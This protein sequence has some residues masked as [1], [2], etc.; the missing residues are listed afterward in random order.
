MSPTFAMHNA[1]DRTVLHPVV[2]GKDICRYAVLA[3]LAYLAYIAL[4]QL[5]TPM[6]LTAWGTFG[7]LAH[8]LAISSRDTPRSKARR[9]SVTFRLPSFI[10][11]IAHVVLVRTSKQVIIAYAHAVITVV[12]NH[13]V[14]RYRT[15]RDLI[16]RTMGQYIVVAS[17]SKATVAEGIR[18]VCPQ[19]TAIWIGRFIYFR[20]KAG[21][22]FRSI[23][24]V[25]RNLLCGVMPRGATNTAGAFVCSNYSIGK[26]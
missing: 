18:L 26:P 8:A 21:N 5:G 12:A 13:Q 1:P 3:L 6:V 15:I 24:G 17:N 2:F 10:H 11:H 19:P 22:E 4:G 7:M 25:H 14:V 20:P 16:C 23:L 9:I